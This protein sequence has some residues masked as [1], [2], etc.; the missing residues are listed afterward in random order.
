MSAARVGLDARLTRQ[1]SAGMQTYVRELTARLPR[2]APEYDYV[3]FAAGS[4]FDWSEQIALPR[5]M[6]RAR[7]DLVHFLSQYVPVLAPSPFVV[8]IHDLIHLRFPQYFK[9]KVAP[10]YATVVRLACARARRVI[11]DDERTVEDLA[12]FLGVKRTKVRVIPLGAGELFNAAVT[13]YRGPR[14]YLLYV[15]NHREHKDLPTLFDAWSA[16]PEMREIDLYLTG[17]DDF[18]GELQRRSGR[19]R[20]IVALGDVGADRLASYYA[21]ARALVQPALREGFG[22]PML[23]AMMTGCPVIA[24]AEAV[25]GVLAPAALTFPARDARALESTLDRILGDE[26][27]RA[28]TSNLGKGVSRELTWDRCARATADVYREVLEEG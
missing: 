11:T 3:P 4:N 25:P 1:L 26:G 7:L 15:G 23:E 18:G 5:A 13:P 6:R 10:Y 12:L 17:P 22:L 9:A 8:T 14:P 16:L 24:C 2:V 19:T 21:G 28:R 27:L 20:A